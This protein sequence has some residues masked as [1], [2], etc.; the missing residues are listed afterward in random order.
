MRR[1]HN[2]ARCAM[3]AAPQRKLAYVRV[4]DQSDI[5][6]FSVLDHVCFN[7][8]S[9]PSVV[10]TILLRIPSPIE[11]SLSAGGN[12]GSVMTWLAQYQAGGKYR[13]R[14][15]AAAAAGMAAVAY[16]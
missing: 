1:A 14:H 13:H 11:H 5:R 10:R 7:S 3:F 9:E 6:M 4:L 15:L 12:I 8:D 2:A 16:L